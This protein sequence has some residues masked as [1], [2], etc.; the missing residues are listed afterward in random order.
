VLSYE[1]Q[2]KLLA[3]RHVSINREYL[4]NSPCA[5]ASKLEKILCLLSLSINRFDLQNAHDASHFS[6]NMFWFCNIFGGRK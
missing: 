4:F 1:V 6:T 2:K 3:K 5:A